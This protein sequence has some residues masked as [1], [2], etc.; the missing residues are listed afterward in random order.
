MEPQEATRT[1]TEAR[2]IGVTA[3][4]RGADL[5][6]ADLR[7]ADL[8]GADLRGA[9]LRSANLYS[10]DLYGADLRSADLCA[11]NLRSADLRSADLYGANL[12]GADLRSAD[13]RSADLYGANLYG[14]DL[15]NTVLDPDEEPNGSADE[16]GKDGDYVVG[17]RT[18][19]TGHIDFY[20]DGRHYSAEWFSVDDAEC[21]PG[22]YL[23]PTLKLAIEFSG[24]DKKF[25]RVRTKPTEIHKAG[26]KWRCRWFEVLGSA[27]NK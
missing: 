18:R 4:L 5:Y 19:R 23:W 20:R 24:V 13:L 17:F 3:N 15:R 7:S 11:A 14:A 9:N 21:H 25:I 22:L 12:Y 27:P 6:G 1:V 8:R 16:F 26:G 2:K 10:A